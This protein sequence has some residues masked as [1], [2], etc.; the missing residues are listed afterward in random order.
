MGASEDKVALDF[1]TPVRHS[2][3][4]RLSVKRFVC[5][6]IFILGTWATVAGSGEV[7]ECSPLL[8]PPCVFVF[9][10][11]A[12]A[13]HPVV[14]LAT[15]VEPGCRLERIFVSSRSGPLVLLVG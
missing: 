1:G 5:G 14:H 4:L 7:P 15:S 6:P 9:A 13:V 10:A 12:V 3:E 8:R 2:R 11:A